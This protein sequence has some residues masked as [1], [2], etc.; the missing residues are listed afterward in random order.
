[1]SFWPIQ[2]SDSTV[3]LTG[4]FSLGSNGLSNTPISIC[5]K[6]PLMSS[7]GRRLKTDVLAL[8]RPVRIFN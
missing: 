8:S 3:V 2:Y 4:N 5:E 6:N 1:M 7:K